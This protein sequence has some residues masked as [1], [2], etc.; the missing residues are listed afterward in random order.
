MEHTDTRWTDEEFL[1]LELGDARLNRR[2]MQLG[3]SAAV[4]PHGRINA[5][6]GDGAEKE[7]AYRF[8]E[9]RRVEARRIIKAS[10]DAAMRRAADNDLIVVVD[11]TS[12]SYADPQ[13]IRGLGRVGA[14]SRRRTARAVEVMTATC[15]ERTRDVSL[16][17]VGQEWF[18]RREEKSPRRPD[19]RCSIDKESSWW[20]AIMSAATTNIRDTRPDARI[21]FVA[22]RGADFY[23]VY[24]AATRLETDFIVR[25][26]NDRRLVDGGH[27]NE[28]LRTTRKL[29]KLKRTIR[30]KQ[31]K[32]VREKKVTLD[33]RVA[34]VGLALRA[35]HGGKRG[36]VR[37]TALR[38][39][40]TRRRLQWTLLTSWNVKTLKD[41]E[42][43]VDAY[44]RRWRIED[45]HRSWK[46]GCCRVE[47]AQLRSVEAIKTWATILAVV[48][49]RVERLKA[50]ARLEPDRPASD[51]LSE[52]E[53]KAL[54][55]ISG[56]KN[57]WPKDWSKMTIGQAA[58]LIGYLGGWGGR[59]Q[60]PPGSVT[61]GRGLERV[62]G[63]A[64]VVEAMA[65]QK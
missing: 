64:V 10:A 56:E 26:A 9:N 11:Q 38:I 14:D 65:K 1:T 12:L 13:R 3:A 35:P 34:A 41:A 57:H 22:D 27:L 33:V 6:F 19:R 40:D 53:I 50:L 31:G 18:V 20:V 28:H 24:N 39:T 4:R 46:S 62:Q 25:A 42:A 23:G 43:V 60:G 17:L 15:F 47:D 5:V 59:S 16:G 21:T 36:E 7:A 49:A 54:S 63:A 55:L 2:L 58:I 30:V 37:V 48:A 52:Y 32:M 44:C 8:V 29:G 45:F 61:L 51:E